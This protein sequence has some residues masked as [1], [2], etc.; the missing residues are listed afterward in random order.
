MVKSGYDFVLT[1]CHDLSQRRE[2]GVKTGFDLYWWAFKLP[3]RPVNLWIEVP[4]PW[5]SQYGSIIPE[6]GH[7]ESCQYF[8]FSS[9]ND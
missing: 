8:L 9:R 7:V 4:E 1:L 6:V 2:A 5:V 3:C